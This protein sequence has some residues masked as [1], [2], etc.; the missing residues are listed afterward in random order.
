MHLVLE[1][2]DHAFY[3][4]RCSFQCD[5]HVTK[6]GRVLSCKIAKRQVPVDELVDDTIDKTF[7]NKIDAYNFSVELLS[8]LP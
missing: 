5:V 6:H 7:H 3:C 4:N 1:N 2:G 8:E